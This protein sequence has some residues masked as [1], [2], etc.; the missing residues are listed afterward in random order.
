MV[1]YRLK[2]PLLLFLLATA[3][4][5]LLWW[6]QP[7]VIFTAAALFKSEQVGY[8]PL[9]LNPN[10]RLLVIAPH[11][12]DEVLA[13]GGLLAMAHAQGLP[14]KVIVVTMGDS[15]KLACEH[16]SGKI[17]PTAADFFRLGLQRWQES[18]QGLTRLGL[19]PDQQAVYLGFPDGGLRFLWEQSWQKP[20]LSGGVRTDKV[21]YPQARQPGLSYTGENLL[22]SLQAEIRAFQPTDIFYPTPADE[23]P[24]HWAVGTFTEIALQELQLP[25]RRHT[26]L[27]HHVAWPALWAA[28]PNREAE[29]PPRLVG[30]EFNW[31]R[32][33][34]NNEAKTAKD[35][36]LAAHHSQLAVMEPYLKGFLR[37][38][39]IFLSWSDYNLPFT[40][41]DG[42]LDHVRV[43]L[44]PGEDIKALAIQPTASDWTANLQ[45]YGT[46]ER[47]SSYRLYLWLYRDQ[48]PLAHLL[49]EG[50]KA[51][52]LWATAAY[53]LATK[54]VPFHWQEKGLEWQIPSELL[55]Q[56]N[57]VL[58]AGMTGSN[59]KQIADKTGWYWVKLQ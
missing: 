34:L 16:S 44:K 13:T 26:Y 18:R 22:Q 30:P 10:Q 42:E 28:E 6:W 46:P 48:H 21:P 2:Y 54:K 12:D 9:Q 52:V 1:N 3:V 32:L 7:Q 58:L 17:E 33:K 51:R 57:R 27:V 39:E 24:D 41:P 36:A 49:L 20:R 5:S 25:V 14:V 50:D 38:S 19:K 29:P 45:L 8:T 43:R 11:P 4:S 31:E 37:A 47:S 23:H 35:Q 59:G 15:F 40:M 56:A 53:N 55:G